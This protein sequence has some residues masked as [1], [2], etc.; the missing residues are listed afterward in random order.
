MKHLALLLGMRLRS[1]WNAYRFARPLY[2]WVG[3]GLSGGSFGFFVLIFFLSLALLAGAEAVGGEPAR[4]RLIE[5]GV[6]FLFLFL[7]A[8]AVPF[9]SATLL[10]PGDLSLL[11]ATP[12]RPA[13]VVIARLLDAA[14]V[15]SA[16]FLVIGVPLLFAS[17]AALH[18][19]VGGW[20]AF[21]VLLL[22]FLLL[23]PF[24]VAALLLLLARL[25][26]MRRLRAAVA[27]LSA[28][29]AVGMCLLLVGEFAR[30]AG[31][32]GG[33]GLAL[34]AATMDVGPPPPRWLPST[35]M[36]RA[37]LALDE[38]AGALAPAG[39]LLAAT[40]AAGAAA[41]GLGRGVLLG[42][43]L[44]E[45]EG[46]GAGARGESALEGLL[47]ALPISPPVRALLAKDARY[48]A[49]DLV[50]LS[51]I[52]IPAILYFVPFVI[53]GQLRGLGIGRAELFLFSASMVVTIVYMETSILSLSSVG[54]E[55]RAFWVVLHAP[56]SITAFVRAKFLAAFAGS[57]LLCAPLYLLS[58][59]LFAPGAAQTLGGLGVLLVACA[60]LCGLGVGI[61]G[62]F[63]RFVYENPAHRASLS[64]LVWGFVGAT[65][66]V[67]ASSVALGIGFLLAS[68]WPERTG[69][70]V[71]VSAG[72][73]CLLS[74]LA[75][76]APL[77]L[78]CRRLDG[79]AWEE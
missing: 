40:L 13:A 74:L 45:G 12:A 70:F 59:A 34:A 7:L 77:L 61:A 10:A 36:S 2:R 69:L 33:R 51:Q 4:N 63:P 19:N 24:F 25:V 16:Q 73:F 5:R 79:Y 30:E 50:L 54:L 39:L 32:S 31:R 67:I 1:A 29:L 38:P 21:F 46:T 64:A 17:A 60:A 68:R 57:A 52:G 48:V 47:R 9:V 65:A 41:L 8:G 37:L 58:C 42:E 44:L 18:L 11:L 71:G 75:G 56:V 23:P 28:V 6:Q 78:A 55:G 72:V 53:A 3:M 14:A 20:A 62:L 22:L 49:R 27:L 26:G 15:A 76:L 43:S 66:Y 35:W